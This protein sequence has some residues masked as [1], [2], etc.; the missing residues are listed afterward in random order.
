M[1]MD[2]TDALPVGSRNLGRSYRLAILSRKLKATQHDGNYEISIHNALDAT[3]ILAGTVRSTDLIFAID[4]A[5][6]GTKISGD[7]LDL[8]ESCADLTMS[9]S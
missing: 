3:S 4:T 5:L 1:K 2:I 7:L 8:L 9:K 6:K